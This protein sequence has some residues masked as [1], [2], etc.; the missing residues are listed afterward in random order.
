MTKTVEDAGYFKASN[1]IIDEIAVMNVSETPMAV[2][3]RWVNNTPYPD[4]ST[5]PI[6]FV[7]LPDT[8]E[9]HLFGLAIP[10]EDGLIYNEPQ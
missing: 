3:N 5:V 1:K 4:Q 9:L 2:L 10:V 8:K 6:D 7:W